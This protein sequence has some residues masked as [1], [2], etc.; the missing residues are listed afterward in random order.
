[1]MHGSE[2]LKILKVY[3]S[4]RENCVTQ[5]TYGDVGKLYLTFYAT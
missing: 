3:F 1:M 2:Y 4:Y 5:L